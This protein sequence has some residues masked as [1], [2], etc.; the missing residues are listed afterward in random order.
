ML[1]KSVIKHG[2][3]IKLILL[4]MCPQRPAPYYVPATALDP[5]AFPS[6][7]VWPYCLSYGQA[8]GPESVDPNLTLK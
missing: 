4:V 5:L 7:S 6:R 8:L 1:I 2:S 3:H